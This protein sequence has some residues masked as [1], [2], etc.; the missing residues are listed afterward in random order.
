M[1]SKLNREQPFLGGVIGPVFTFAPQPFTSNAPS[2]DPSP[3]ARLYSA[4]SAVN[5]A[6]PGT[7]LFPD[8]VA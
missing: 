2:T 6:T 4:P 3:V 1:G 8:G 5:P 7:L